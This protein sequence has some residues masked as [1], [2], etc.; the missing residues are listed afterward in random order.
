MTNTYTASSNIQVASFW[1]QNI[2]FLMVIQIS[3]ERK[4]LHFTSR[5]VIFMASDVSPSSK[6][7]DPETDT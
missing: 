6:I 1:F 5:I 7:S 2:T 3:I 4:G